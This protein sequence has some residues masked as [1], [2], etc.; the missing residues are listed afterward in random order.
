MDLME[1]TITIAEG[2]R[3]VDISANGL[4]HWIRKGELDV[5]P[6]PLGNLVVKRSLEEFLKQRLERE[7]IG[8]NN[9]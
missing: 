4:R 2:A 6:T 3:R 9:D 7:R 8:E 5:V 1:T